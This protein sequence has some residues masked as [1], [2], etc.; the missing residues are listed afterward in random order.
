MHSKDKNEM[1][2]ALHYGDK[3]VA[4][5]RDD[6]SFGARKMSA[7]TMVIRGRCLGAR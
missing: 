6:E 7:E 3:C 5:G 2:G 1:Q 4:F